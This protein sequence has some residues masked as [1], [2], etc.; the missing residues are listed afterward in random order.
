V[1]KNVTNKIFLVTYTCDISFSSAPCKSYIHLFFIYIFIIF[2]FTFL[3]KINSYLLFG[4]NNFLYSIIYELTS[5]FLTNLTVYI[6]CTEEKLIY[7]SIY[8][9]F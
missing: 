4:F 1:H 8:C 6:D 3:K 9:K 7:I 5:I 2:S